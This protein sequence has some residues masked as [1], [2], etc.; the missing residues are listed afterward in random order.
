MSHKRSAAEYFR[1]PEF[2]TDLLQIAKG[3]IAATGAWWFSDAVLE[4]QMPFLAPWTAL[5][6]VHA[7]VYRSFSRGVQT[8]IASTIGVG[9]SFLIGNYLG[10]GL[11]TFALA[12]FVGLAGA[13]L[14]WIRDE[15]VAIAT[16]AI[17]ILGSGF[18]SQ[19]PLLVD[20]L[21]ELALGVGVGLAV[22]LLMVP[23]LRDRQAARYIDSVNRQMGEVLTDMSKQF[24]RS[25]DSEAAQEWFERTEAMSRELESA[26]QTVR[27]ARESR[28]INP[29]TAVRLRSSRGGRATAESAEPA[30]KEGYESI[31]LRVDEGISHL[32]N[33]ARTL[34][35]ASSSETE[36]NTW[37]RE[38][39]ASIVADAGEAIADP[40]S[41]VEPIF[42]SLEQ[43][44]TDIAQAQTLPKTTW[45]LYGSLITSLRH[46]VVIVDDVASAR[47]ARESG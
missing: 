14:S 37:F 41:E 42:D 13:R 7:T 40:D 16:T 38:E 44:S 5:L 36:W 1:R 26:W 9:V 28:R 8:T 3:V 12:M 17:F 11:W 31:L 47:R 30:E 46:I 45:P 10:V 32:R 29:R 33:L 24:S 23:P 35:E 18:D 4:S 6:T 2:A 20:R 34:R 19:Q 21:L 25:W 43:L 39:W 27:F 22:N 15:G